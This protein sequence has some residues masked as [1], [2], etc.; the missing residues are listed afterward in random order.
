MEFKDYYAVLGVPKSAPTD[1]IK[2]AY[3]KLARQ[4]HPDVSKEANAEH[5]FKEINEAWEVLQDK[6]K[7]AHYD[8]LL[9]S[10]YK[11]GSEFHGNYGDR[12]QQ[13]YQRYAH[14]GAGGHHQQQYYSDF[15]GD[16]QE[17][18]SEFFN[19]IFGQQAAQGAHRQ[20]RNYKAKGRDLHAKVKIPLTTAFSGG[21][22]TLEL[23]VPMQTPDG[24]V[25]PNTKSL[26]VKIPAGVID[27]SQIRLKGQGGMGHGGG[28]NGDLYIEIE[29]IP[30]PFFTVHQ[31]DIHLKLPVTPWEAAL[32]ATLAVPTLAGPVNLKIPANSQSEQKMRLKGRGMPGETPGDQFVILEIMVPQAKTDADKELFQKMSETMAFNPR[33]K[34]GV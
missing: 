1:D 24:G 3:R 27:G 7:R 23:Q 33:E 2:R 9:N 6:E 4:Y 26:N 12:S 10:G 21:V 11:P 25:A 28:P 22:Q 32:G 18:F 8:E 29:I 14:P 16:G 17:D 30:H 13:Q 19:S 20:G 15:S 31:R 5:K 34:L